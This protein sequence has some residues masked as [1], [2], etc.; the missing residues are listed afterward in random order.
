MKIVIVILLFVLCAP[1]FALERNLEGKTLLNAAVG[2][3]YG[4]KEGFIFHAKPRLLRFVLPRL[5][6]GLDAE[7]Y[8]EDNYSRFGV[9]PSA[10]FHFLTIGRLDFVLGQHVLYSKESI[11]T[12]G[13]IG[14][15]DL[16]AQYSLTENFLLGITLG[17][18]YYLT[19]K[20]TDPKDPNFANIAFIFIF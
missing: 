1:S 9:G 7:Y 18:M 4:E 8:R 16:G 11:H 17:K 10:D 19:K 12:P 14:T 15:T 6:V 2:I 20:D 3:G 13:L 5:A